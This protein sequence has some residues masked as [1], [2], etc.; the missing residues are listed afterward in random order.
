MADRDIAQNLRACANQHAIAD[1]GV[2]VL[3]LFAGAAK[4][5]R[6]Q[7]RDVVAHHRRLTDDDG[8]RVVDHDALAHLGRR[9]DIHAKNLAHPHLD[10]IGQIALALGIE[11]MA[12]AV[13]LHRLIAFEIQNRLQQSVAGRVAVIDGHEIG[14]RRGDEIGVFGIGF[15][16]HLAHDHHRHLVR[17]KLGRDA[18]GKRI[19]DR[20]MVQDTGMHKA[21]DQRLITHRILGLLL[22]LVPNRVHFRDISACLRHGTGSFTLP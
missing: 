14:T 12:H 7:H 19:L 21:A 6:M 15:F 4:G 13:G 20:F 11:V 17:R 2:T 16:D 8:M 5:H 9:M 10:E 3:F 1:L 22:N 18:V